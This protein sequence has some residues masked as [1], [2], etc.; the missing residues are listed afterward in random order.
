MLDVCW[1]VQ[2]YYHG[3][4]AIA[5]KLASIMKAMLLKKNDYIAESAQAA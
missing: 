3:V 4:I 5:R 2:F 1:M